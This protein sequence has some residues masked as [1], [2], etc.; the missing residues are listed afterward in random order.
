MKLFNTRFVSIVIILYFSG[1]ALSASGAGADNKLR[2]VSQVVGRHAGM[3]DVDVDKITP[4]VAVVP[5]SVPESASDLESWGT[6]FAW[7]I[8]EGLA[9][10]GF[11][12]VSSSEI[13]G[14][15]AQIG[16]PPTML[17]KTDSVL[18][19]GRQALAQYVVGGQLVQQDGRLTARIQL[20]ETKGGKP[21]FQQNYAGSHDDPFALQ[22]RIV[23]GLSTALGA[24][25]SSSSRP[26]SERDIH[27]GAHDLFRAHS[28]FLK[29][30]FDRAQSLADSAI[31]KAPDMAEAHYIKG[32]SQLYGGMNTDCIPALN[33]AVELN[34]R[35]IEA[36]YALVLAYVHLLQDDPRSLQ[37]AHRIAEIAPKDPRGPLAL[38]YAHRRNP[39]QRARYAQ[40]VVRLSPYSAEAH[41]GLALSYIRQADDR[42]ARRKAEAAIAIATEINPRDSQLLRIKCIMAMHDSRIDDAIEYEKEALRE[43]AQA[44]PWMR[45]LEYEY[46]RSLARLYLAKTFSLVDS[47]Q[48]EQAQK[49]LEEAVYWGLQGYGGR[50]AESSGFASIWDVPV[51]TLYQSQQPMFDQVLDRLSRRE[52][53]IKSHIDAYR[54]HLRS[55]TASTASAM[56]AILHD[57]ESIHKTTG[58]DRL[59]NY[60]LS[61]AYGK[62]VAMDGRVSQR[63]ATRHVEL[64]RFLAELEPGNWEVTS[65]YATTLCNV[66]RFRE[67]EQHLLKAARMNP[68]AFEPLVTLGQVYMQQNKTSDARRVLIQAAEKNSNM[69]VGYRLLA[70]IY[71]QQNDLD[72]LIRYS[73]AGIQN[74]QGQVPT[75]PVL[76][77]LYVMAAGG[78]IDKNDFAKAR[79]HLATGIR[80]APAL[81]NDPQVQQLKQI[82][83]MR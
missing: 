55:L 43:N 15:I 69:A 38:G 47:Q 62:T 20:Y 81:A 45:G 11:S 77:V 59:V 72:M 60:F 33:R 83:N 70:S 27:G 31:R 5:F 41:V 16:I 68:D 61:T 44:T 48:E 42:N 6:G 53:G 78:Y 12:P 71:A 80:L 19:V 21:L 8:G 23:A 57:L 36:H 52:A 22:D 25:L 65:N 66:G 46:Q 9:P 13:H 26:E 74:T 30:L 18:V 3:L 82:L 40:E 29:G 73:E 49:A 10:A 39:E 37:N 1:S 76:P 32:M 58:N 4:R 54:L 35:L 24:A 75:D 67:A 28:A 17:S 79:Q 51:L 14:I 56:R 7:I 2:R 50:L 63:D 64:L 34:D